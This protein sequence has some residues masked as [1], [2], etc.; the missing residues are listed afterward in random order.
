MSTGPEFQ[1]SNKAWK[2]REDPGQVQSVL[3][4]W[5]RKQRG[6]QG[7]ETPSFLF[8][9]ELALNTESK[10]WHSEAHKQSRN[11]NIFVVTHFVSLY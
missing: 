1:R 3:R 10:P 4:P 8:K 9:P 2:F 5:L 6:A 11:A 7:S